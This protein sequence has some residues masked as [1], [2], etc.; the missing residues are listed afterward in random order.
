MSLCHRQGTHTHTHHSSLKF[1]LHL[2]GTMYFWARASCCHGDWHPSL[3][4]HSSD[5]WRCVRRTSVGLSQSDWMCLSLYWDCFKADLLGCSI[6]RVLMFT[7]IA[8]NWPACSHVTLLLQKCIGPPKK[9]NAEWGLISLHWSVCLSTMSHR[10]L[11]SCWMGE[12]V[13]FYSTRHWKDIDK[14]AD[15]QMVVKNNVLFCQELAVLSLLH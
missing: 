3:G 9:K 5:L 6:W 8:Q 14:I 13:F 1:S 10:C 11:Q 2:T 12:T 15:I 7:F 4:T